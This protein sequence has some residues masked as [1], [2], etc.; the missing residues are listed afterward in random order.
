MRLSS[1]KLAGFKSF[2][3]PTQ[4]HLSTNLSGIVGPNGCGKSNIIDAVRW[5][6]G[7]SAASR[8]RGDALTDVIFSGSSGRKPVGT[9]SVELL[10]D[11]SDGAIGGEYA[12]YAEISVK[13][14]VGRDGHSLYALNGVQCRRRDITD[15]FLGTGLGPRSYSIIEQGTITEIVESDPESMRGH[16]EEAA[17]ISRYRERRKETESRMKATRENLDRVRDVGEE[18][19][20]QLAHLARQAR[21]AERWQKLDAEH[22]R[23]RAELSALN[24]RDA[25]GALDEQTTSRR[26]AELALEEMIAG[27]RHGE[28]ELEAARARYESAGEAVGAA[29][30]EV[31]RIGSEIARIEQQIR[32]H[33]ELV[34]ELQRAAEESDRTHATLAAQLEVDGERL[35]TLKAELG[36]DAP[37]FAEL[38]ARDADASAALQAAE[39]A[40][41][42]WQEQWD[43]NSG[44]V[45]A[46]SREA[47]IDRTRIGLLEAQCRQSGERRDA[48]VAER[49]AIDTEA[50]SAAI[51][52]MAAEHA[53]LAAT[54]ASHESRLT[55]HMAEAENANARERSAEAALSALR[56]ERANIAGRREALEAL[57][58]T[59]PGERD[60]RL[61]DWLQ[62]AGVDSPRRLGEALD[63]DAGWDAAV[64]TVLDAWLGAVLVGNPTALAGRFPQFD[65][66]DI[67]LLADGGSIAGHAP[68]SLAAHVRG[69]AAVMALLANVHAADS[70]DAARA[71]LGTLGRGASVVART[72]EWF[73]EGFVRVRH[74]TPAE[75]GILAREREL[76]ALVARAEDLDRATAAAEAELGAARMARELAH[77]RVG[78]ANDALQGHRRAFAGLDGQLQ[79]HQGRLDAANDRIGR[80][81]AELAALAAT[82]D[83]GGTEIKAAR[84]RLDAAV[85]RMGELENDRRALDARRRDLLESREEARATAREA[86]DAVHR[87]TVSLETRRAAAAGLEE[88]LQ[89]SRA[90]MT[91]LE[92]R[93]ADIA[94]RLA[95]SGDPAERHEAERQALL[96]QRLAADQALVTA[97]QAHGTVDADVRRLE[98]ERHRSEQVLTERRDALGEL[99]LREQE[100]RLHAE[101]LAAEIT[102]AGFR[103]A[104][105]LE[106][107]PADLS[108][109]ERQHEL[110][111]LAAKMQ[112]LEPVNLAAIQEHDELE[113]RKAYLDAQMADLGAAL[114]TLEGAIRKIDKETRQRFR[115]TFERVN[116][117]LQELFPRLFGGGHA[118]LELTG[119]DL[120]TAGVTI[121][122]RPPGKRVSSISLLSGGEKAMTAVAIVFAIFRLNPAPF[123]LLDEVDAPLDEVSIGRFSALVTEMSEKV[124]FIFVTHNKATME[125][126]MQLCGVT[127]REPG[128]SRLVQVDLAEAERLAGAA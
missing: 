102:A 68:T 108:G 57:Q 39:N 113:Q 99:R 77:R 126:A 1:I 85:G 79:G 67:D 23:K 16:L 87:M 101:A 92:A 66:V 38:T 94:A 70:N 86:H 34:A 89:R 98:Q 28:S 26:Q 122:A 33:R 45:A 54:I 48:L 73:G 3:D 25:R 31:Y 42:D 107:L 65:D 18:V 120:L 22:K 82:L 19:A 95:A 27:Q 7:E 96:G 105:L 58:H 5:V 60:S 59:T 83:D 104:E 93:R 43:R 40:L 17:G 103:I 4:L 35:R 15:L 71:L 50:L 32:H 109:G 20:K 29:Q 81:T 100:H 46:A 14:T 91:D 116:A 10:F 97:R 121:M 51:R 75:S 78:E 62:Q 44:A 112:R 88:S 49:T 36:D 106:A 128:V 41:A 119:D 69:P 55:D 9:A 8:L 74:G 56:A 114:E 115:E 123:C 30:A 12:N 76:R 11:N 61:R 6:M 52:D 53:S 13:R 124:Q 37:G 47:E 111:E 117:G 64:E 63:V 21:A 80:I 24:L 125:A 90:R 127:M 118:Y 72:G 110:D 2:V 84:N